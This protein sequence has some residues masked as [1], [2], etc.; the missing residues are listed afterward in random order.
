MDY[1][2]VRVIGAGADAVDRRCRRYGETIGD[3]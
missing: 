3:G 1:S 2:D